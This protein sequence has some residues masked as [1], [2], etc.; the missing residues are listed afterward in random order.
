M[1][2]RPNTR[3]IRQRKFCVYDMEWTPHDL[4]L[5]LIGCYDGDKI[6]FYENIPDF[7]NGEL[8]PARNGYWFY[9][10]AGGLYDLQFILKYLIEKD[11]SH[12][13]LSAAFAGSS[14]IIVKIQ[15]GKFIWYLIDSFWLLR[16][17]L[18]KIGEWMGMKKG[19]EEQQNKCQKG[20]MQGAICTCPR[21]FYAEG[22]ELRDY[23]GQDCKILWHAIYDFQEVVNGLGGELQMTIAST[24]LDL[25][26]RK[27]LTREIKTIP[28]LNNL[29]KGA[30]IASRVE[31]HE[32]YCDYADYWD[33]NSS[34]PYA[35]TFDAP[36]N[37]ISTRTTLPETGIYL[38]RCRI[39][40]PDMYLPPLP[41]RTEDHRVYFPVG[42]WEEWFC[43][44]DLE[45]L[46]KNGG[47]I[48][49]VYEVLEFEEFDDLKG[50]AETIYT[51]RRD[52]PSKAFKT[53]LKYLLN[54]LYGKFSEKTEKQK[55]LMHPDITT[56]THRKKGE[57][58][59][60][61]N[62]CM[63]LWRPG[64]FILTEERNIPHAHLPIAIHITA[65]ARGVLYDYMKQCNKV[66]YCDTDGFACPPDNKF[67]NSK[68]LGK[69]KHEKSI[70]E[71]RFIA[72]KLYSYLDETDI[73]M[74]YFTS[75]DGYTVK[76]KGFSRLSYKEFCDL[77]NGQD[78]FIEKFSRIREC[79]RRGKAMPEVIPF[80][81]R[82]RGNLRPKRR[83]VENGASE[84][85]NILDLSEHYSRDS[86]PVAAE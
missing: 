59:H 83:F 27:F 74:A 79:L 66:Y 52:S 57:A 77:V 2:L 75:K 40:V 9:A 1:A 47:E 12:I 35:M 50:Y 48:I 53:F 36:G 84:P 19:G 5:K 31:V 16:E 14:A 78:V 56:C 32:N 37:L 15:K 64:V 73:P 29:V 43:N 28:K 62:E 41:H 30:Y 38:A 33:V 8:T 11:S 23:N 80:A 55:M 54:A 20:I 70:F 85:W 10:H 58:L 42:E 7:L 51:M 22:A 49:K 86:S 26:R 17:S 3:P 18:R 25:F 69:L 46:Q 44:V 34:F 63:T 24:A 4:N 60:P 65:I 71:G 72:P 61:N 67:E 13:K 76:S 82:L 39:K 81:K 6:N 45:V 68:E 21:I